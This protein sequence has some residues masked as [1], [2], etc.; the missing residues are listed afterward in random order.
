[1]PEPT[2][3]WWGAVSPFLDQ[4]LELPPEGRAG[5]LAALRRDNPDAA[6][7][8]EELLGEHERLAR[9]GFL[10]GDHGGLR[11]GAPPT[12]LIVGAYRLVSPIGEG[13]MGTV[14]LAERSDGEIQQRVAVKLLGAGG[15]RPGWRER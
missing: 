14:W 13:G 6:V 9:D 4:V 5:W 8:V 10:D 2:S 15:R 7:R 3:E 1:M 12:P 11:G